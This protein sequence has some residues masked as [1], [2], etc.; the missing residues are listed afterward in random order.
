MCYPPELV[1]MTNIS[2]TKGQADFVM[3]TAKYPAFCAGYGAG[4]S[5][6]MGL[7]VALD[8]QHS[9]NAIIGVYEPFHDLIRTVAWP[10]VQKW[11]TE[12]GIRY[13]LNKQDSAIYTSNDGVGDIYFKSMDNVEALVGYETYTSH[14]DE[15]DTMSMDNAEK[16]FFKIMGRNRQAPKDVPQEYRKWIEKTQQWECINK[17]RIYT[18]PEGFKFCYKMW[19]PNSE[20]VKK[21]P[22][23]KL[24][25]GRT[26]DNP[27]LTEDYIQG[28]RDTYP[29]ALLKAY[30]EGEFVNMESGAVYYNFCRERHNTTRT[31]Q[32]DDVLHIGIDFNV[33]HTC[34]IVFVDEGNKTSVVAEVVNKLD[35]PALIRE[36]KARWPQHVII[37]Y[38]DSSGKN[39]NSQ[40]ASEDANQVAQLRE[41]GF[42]I[43]RRKKNPLINNRIASVIK[44]FED[45]KLY[46]NV[47]LC[48]ELTRCL[49]QQAYND[50]GKPDKDSGL[51]HPLDGMGYKVE[52]THSIKKPVYRIPYSF[53]QKR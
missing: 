2:L 30:M 13:T 51:D 50:K 20:N 6:T 1:K 21:N 24:Y 37:A 7:C 38:P 22:E 25:R 32:P 26:Q 3:S 45:D 19:A 43:R 10:N 40:N 8:V 23:F 11:L 33:Q 31:I 46:I 35:T 28:L 27:E 12:L 42:R 52:Y 4:K 39:R 44:L 17:I 34:G 14:I 16:A 49:E 53:A 36:I 29:T 18:T 47:A 9:S 15:L 41:A 5:H 48:P